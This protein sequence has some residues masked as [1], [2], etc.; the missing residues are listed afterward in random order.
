[1]KKELTK[2]RKKMARKMRNP[3]EIRNGVSIYDSKEYAKRREARLTRNERI[4][5][6][7]HERAVKRKKQV[8]QTKKKGF[9]F[10]K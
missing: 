2:K 10:F 5:S 1:M 4:K 9:S 3:A 6:K 8:L 7:A